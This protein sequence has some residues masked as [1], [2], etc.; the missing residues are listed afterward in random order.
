MAGLPG[1]LDP[2]SFELVDAFRRHQA[3]LER[4]R[5]AGIEPDHFVGRPGFAESLIPVWGSGREAIAD[6]QEGDYVGAG[7]NGAAAA[8]DLFLA[9]AAGKGSQ[10]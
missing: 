5:V 8:S 10:R 6:F 7:I 9:G 1:P 3:D 4:R 2:R